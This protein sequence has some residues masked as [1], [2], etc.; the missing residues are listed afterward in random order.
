MLSGNRKD[1]QKFMCSSCGK[2]LQLKD[3]RKYALRGIMVIS[4]IT[5]FMLFLGVYGMFWYLL[6]L[7]PAFIVIISYLTTTKSRYFYHCSDCYLKF[8]WED[9]CG[10]EE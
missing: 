10:K 5:P 9:E 7:I 2:E 1:F 3:K 4:F 8:D 6:S